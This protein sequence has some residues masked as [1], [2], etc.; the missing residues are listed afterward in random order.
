MFSGF[1]SFLSRQSSTRSS[2]NDV[3]PNLPPA[4]IDDTIKLL[5][6]ELDC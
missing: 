5:N 4:K 2:Q 1:F 6:I 3:R